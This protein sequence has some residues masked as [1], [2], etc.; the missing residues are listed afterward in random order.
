MLRLS[1]ALCGADTEHLG[2]Q[3][4]N[5]WRVLK[6]GAGEEWRRPVGPIA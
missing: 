3:I 5:P 4:V 6:C 1:I 2:K